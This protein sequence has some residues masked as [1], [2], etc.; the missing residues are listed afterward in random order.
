[1][2]HRLNVISVWICQKSP[3]VV[4]VVNRAWSWCAQVF[5]TG[6]YANRVEGGYGL[7]ILGGKCNVSRSRS[8]KDLNDPKN[9]PPFR[10][11]R[12][13][14]TPRQYRVFINN[15]FGL[16]GETE[17]GQYRRIEFLGRNEIGRV[18]TQM[19]NHCSAPSRAV[20]R[21]C[22]F[23]ISIWSW[24]RESKKP[25]SY[26]SPELPAVQPEITN[27]VTARSHRS[28]SASARAEVPRS[29]LFPSATQNR[30]T[31]SC[32]RVAPARSRWR[33]I[34]AWPARNTSASA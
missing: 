22:L 31:Y 8:V 1:M 33:S 16:H 2:T 15:E 27:D 10:P 28:R 20:R 14:P 26:D 18:C 24:C 17:L 30:L 21:L 19:V 4:L 23:A 25:D 7:S 32:V 5:T 9:C 29:H 6:R 3:E 13:S 11:E 34:R 12:T